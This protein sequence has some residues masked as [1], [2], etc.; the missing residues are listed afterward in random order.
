MIDES[1]LLLVE[2]S[3]SSF[4]Q[5]IRKANDGIEWSTQLMTHSGEELTFQLS[6]AFDFTIAQLEFSIRLFQAHCKFLPLVFRA[7]SIRNIAPDSVDGFLFR[8][9]DRVP[10]YPFIVAILAQIAIFEGIRRLPIVQPGS[11]GGC[12]LTIIG[13]D[14]LQVGLRHKFLD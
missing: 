3:A 4:S 13:M 6:C 5:Q 12:F 14:K 2:L 11:F 7:L 9:G 10:Q 8:Y 1:L